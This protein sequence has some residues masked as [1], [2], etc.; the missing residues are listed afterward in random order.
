MGNYSIRANGKTTIYPASSLARITLKGTY[1]IE[2]YN[3]TKLII[4]NGDTNSTQKLFE[5]T[6]NSNGTISVQSTVGPITIVFIVDSDT[7]KVDLN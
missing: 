1:D 7:P 4:Y 6:S 2:N 5:N 3:R